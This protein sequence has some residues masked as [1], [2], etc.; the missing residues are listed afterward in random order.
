LWEVVLADGE[1][2]DAEEQTL[3]LI[4]TTLGITSED[5]DAAKQVALQDAETG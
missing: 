2:D 3:H 1:R 5:S 4:E